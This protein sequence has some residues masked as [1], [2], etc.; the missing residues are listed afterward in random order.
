VVQKPD[1]H[2]SPVRKQFKGRAHLHP[3]VPTM[4]QTLVPARQDIAVLIA[5]VFSTMLLRAVYRLFFHPL[6]KTPGPRLARVT[7]AWLTK[8]YMSGNWHDICLELHQNYGPIVRIAPEE[9]SFVDA[10]A[11]RKLYSY[12]RAASKVLKVSTRGTFLSDRIHRR[13]GIT[14]GL[15]LESKYPS[16]RKQTIMNTHDDDAKLRQLTL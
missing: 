1:K 15:C 12:S 13:V 7:R 6:A 11:L 2:T 9:V 4:L 10:E 16:S 3:S 5:I 14:L 8:Q